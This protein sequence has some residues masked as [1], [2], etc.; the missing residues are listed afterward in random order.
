MKEA[1]GHEKHDYYKSS[2]SKQQ[3]IW[4]LCC[5]KYNLMTNDQEH[6]SSTQTKQYLIAVC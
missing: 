6:F 5:I 1:G 3:G 2:S 4:V